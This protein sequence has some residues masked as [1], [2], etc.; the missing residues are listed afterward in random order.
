MICTY[1]SQLHSN[2]QRRGS[3][4]LLAFIVLGVITAV[5]LGFNY[6]ASNSMRQ[7]HRL[8]IN[9]KSI[10]IGDAILSLCKKIVE[11]K[12][13]TPEFQ[14][15]F[16]ALQTQD[17][18]ELKNVISIKNPT[19]EYG[20]IM[21]DLWDNEGSSFDAEVDLKFIKHKNFEDREDFVSSNEEMKGSIELKVRYQLFYKVFKKN[22][23]EVLKSDWKSIT[24]KF[25]F[26]RVQIQPMAVR[27]FNLFAQDASGFQEESP[28]D[29]L[30]GKF[31]T[32]TATPQGAVNKGKWLKLNNGI[33]GEFSSLG[34]DKGTIN[35]FENKLA[36]NLLGT[37]ANS[38]KNIYLNLTAGSGDAA[39][40]FHMYRGEAGSSDFYQL[41]TSDY[42]I[43]TSD[44]SVKDPGLQALS[45]KVDKIRRKEG[46]D[47]DITSGFPLYYLA[48]KDYGYS[49]A[50][51]KHK[52]F[53]FTKGQGLIT[54]N[55]MHLFGAGDRGT[56]SFS[57]VFGNVF[58][59][60]LSLSGY[61][62]FK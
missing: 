7:I 49:S 20:A 28:V 43:F 35:P 19:G 33:V 32:I 44:N 45:G 59:R 55:S 24:S 34:A 48:R 42:K 16:K 52:E 22:N 31:N 53:G 57:V 58:R 23:S 15:H 61:K 10:L 27:H 8:Q 60:C 21:S 9:E 37:G 4:T 17:R 56:S 47:V 36:Y 30:G 3:V 11:Q 38:K 29:Y 40:S 25:E 41:F 13:K 39:E 54:A 14:K 50:W 51:A 26:K 62:Q 12:A 2:N 5:G 6:Y 18:V 46:K 1:V